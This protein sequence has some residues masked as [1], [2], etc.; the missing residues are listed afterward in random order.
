MTVDDIKVAD[1]E[2]N[3]LSYISSSS[4]YKN[5]G[6]YKTIN[7]ETDEGS[8]RKRVISNSIRSFMTKTPMTIQING[9]DFIQAKAGEDPNYTLG[10]KIRFLMLDP[11]TDKLERAAFD[12]KKSGDYI[13]YAAKHS[14]K[15]E[16][17]D[18]QLLCTKL[19]SYVEDPEI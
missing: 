15:K 10:N 1:Y 14:F 5:F 19:A 13:I 17:Y 9:R 16:R 6:D 4:T 2:A 12:K 7:Q 3:S 11:L 8:Y 18:I